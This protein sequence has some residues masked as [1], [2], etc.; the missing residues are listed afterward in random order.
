MIC[1]KCKEEKTLED[2]PGNRKTCKKCKNEYERNR[3]AKYR[4]HNNE[5]NKRSYYKI[6]N[7]N[8]EIV[9]DENDTKIC[10][11]CENE[12]SIEQFHFHKTKGT[13]RSMCKMCSSEKRKIRYQNNRK[14][15]IRK[16]SERKNNE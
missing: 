13:I 6:K 3:R 11:I 2:F 1:N 8:K 14:E 12:L 16:T 4:D 7:M 10:T 9:V 5:L 15:E